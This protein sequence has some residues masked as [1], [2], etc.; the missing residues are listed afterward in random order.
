MKNDWAKWLRCDV[1]KWLVGFNGWK[2][3]CCLFMYKTLSVK[4]CR[5][6]EEMYLSKIFYRLLSECLWQTIFTHLLF[7]SSCSATSNTA[8]L[9][10]EGEKSLCFD[11]FQVRSSVNVNTQKYLRGTQTSR[12]RCLEGS[13]VLCS[14]R[15]SE[16]LIPACFVAAAVLSDFACPSCDCLSA[17]FVPKRT[18]CWT[19]MRARLQPSMCRKGTWG[20]EDPD[21][22]GSRSLEWGT[23]VS[24]D[25][26]PYD[27]RGSCQNQGCP[28]TP[29]S[30]SST[31]SAFPPRWWGA[32]GAAFCEENCVTLC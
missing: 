4:G 23:Q 30:A 6:P 7:P 17:A 26:E 14:G 31:R 11:A 16:C 12:E 28:E 21:P 5:S 10:D 20:K 2:E 32:L 15:R 13:L 9:N 24:W 18:L 8:S 19:G 22:G 29:A 1:L 25:V 3:C 27:C